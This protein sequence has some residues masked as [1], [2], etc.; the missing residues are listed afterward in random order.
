MNQ[1]DELWIQS[2][3]EEMAPKIYKLV[4]RRLESQEAADDIVQDAFLAL[5]NKL[6]MVKNHPN[7]EGWLIQA[8]K[9]LIL[10]YLE[11]AD[12]QSELEIPLESD[13]GEINTPPTYMPSSPLA[14]VLPPE[15]NER[16][17]KLLIWFYE[18]R[19]SYQEI[20]DK[21]GEPV[22]TC[23]TQLFRARSRYKKIAQEQ[24]IYF[25]LM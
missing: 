11:V 18:D 10:Q 3:F 5:V 2:L 20:A 14:E 1:S 21:L 23:R 6:D 15:L 13:S 8:S 12:K 7:P 9:Y 22:L 24:K 4:L 16:D 25:Q 19:L 17:R